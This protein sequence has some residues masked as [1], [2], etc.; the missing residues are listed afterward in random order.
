[1]QIERH[2]EVVRLLLVQDL[3]QNIQ[4][5]EDRVRVPAPRLFVSGG[6]P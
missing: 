2:R 4:K 5:A 3:K 6:T 1:M